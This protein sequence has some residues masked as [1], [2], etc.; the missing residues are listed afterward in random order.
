MIKKIFECDQCEAIGQISIKNEEVTV[1]DI[2]YCPICG[3]PL[4]DH[5]EEDEE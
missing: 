3:A 4:L 5:Y 2:V 1:N